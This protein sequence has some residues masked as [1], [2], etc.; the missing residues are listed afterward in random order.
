VPL[1]VSRRTSESRSKTVSEIPPDEWKNHEGG[2]GI[3]GGFSAETSPSRG[4]QVLKRRG[5]GRQCKRL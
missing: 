4:K 2:I 1:R 3:G 5:S